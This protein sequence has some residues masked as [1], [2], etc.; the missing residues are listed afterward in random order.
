MPQLELVGAADE[1]TV[2][3]LP[4]DI[5]GREPVLGDEGDRLQHL[6]ELVVPVLEKLSGSTASPTTSGAVTNRQPLS[7]QMPSSIVR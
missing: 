3:A 6:D 4:G 1:E 5:F 2:D 7:P